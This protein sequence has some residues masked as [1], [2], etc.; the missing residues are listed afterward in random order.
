VAIV[1]V[2]GKAVASRGRNAKLYRTADGGW[3]CIALVEP[4]DAAKERHGTGLV[5]KRWDFG[6]ASEAEAVGIF[7]R[8]ADEL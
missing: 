4:D 8:W 6:A 7:E 3:R 2:V 1:M 5:D